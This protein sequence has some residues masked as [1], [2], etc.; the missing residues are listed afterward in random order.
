MHNNKQMPIL[1][2]EV[3]MVDNIVMYRYYRKEMAN[4]KVIMADSAMPYK[5]KKTCLIQEVVRI[6]HNTSM[7]INRSTK[8]QF[9]SEFS[10]RL[11]ESGYNHRT[12]TR[13]NKKRGIGIRKTS[14]Q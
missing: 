14:G 12:E 13:D 4:S 7:R 1:D 8:T 11:K 5:M 2:L 9:L 6:L 10:L 3:A